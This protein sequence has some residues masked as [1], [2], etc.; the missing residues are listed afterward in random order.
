MLSVVQLKRK[1][2]QPQIVYRQ[3]ALPNTDLAKKEKQA[4]I[5]D[6]SRQADPS[7]VIAACN[8]VSVR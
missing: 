8:G 4:A 3:Q 2:G 7:F 5:F 1:L 6:P